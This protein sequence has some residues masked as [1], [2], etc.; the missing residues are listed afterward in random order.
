MVTARR[1]ELKRALNWAFRV[2]ATIEDYGSALMLMAMILLVFLQVLFRYVV[3]ISPLGAEELARYL[4]IWCSFLVAGAAVRT[5]E[6]ITI[7]ILP[8]FIKS[9]RVLKVLGIFL[10]IIGL[11]LVAVLFWLSISYLGYN[12]RSGERSIALRFPMWVPTSCVFFGT[13]LMTLHYAVK[14][15]R[16]FREIPEW[17]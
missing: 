6:H 1:N 17:K 14:V 9:D 7:N 5:G 10:D 15:I 4:M 16:Q 11:V 12:F 2:L 13:G 8:L 3:H